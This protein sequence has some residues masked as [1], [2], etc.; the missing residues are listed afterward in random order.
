MASTLHTLPI[1]FILFLSSFLVRS[2]LIFFHVSPLSSLWNKKLA[3]KYN[4]SELWGLITNGASQFH[5]KAASPS[6]GWGCIPIL[7]PFD[8]SYLIIPAYCDIVYKIFGSVGSTLT[9]KPSPPVVTN[10]SLFLMPDLFLVL[11]GP[12]KLSLSWVPPYTL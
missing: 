1:T 6:D 3:A 7:S 4:L 8:L 9:W 5:L 2:G 12:P 10:Q 11:E